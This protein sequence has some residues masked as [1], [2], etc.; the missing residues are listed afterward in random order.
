MKNAV[1]LLALVGCLPV[2]PP[3]T[4]GEDTGPGPDTAV[5]NAAPSA[6]EIAL[7]PSAPADAQDLVVT[8]LTPSED[9]EGA[10]V[11]YRYA[12]TVNGAPVALDGDTVPAAETADGQTWVVTV[13]PSDGAIDGDAATASVVIGNAPPTTPALRFEPEVPVPGEAFTLVVDSADPDGD[14][15]VTE[16]TWWVDG[17]EHQGLAD[18]TEIPG[19]Y[20]DGGE[21]YRAL[22]RVSDGLHAPVTAEATVAVGNTPPTV[23]AV[24]VE[25]ERPKDGDALAAVVEGAVDP[26]GHDLAY[27]YVW[28][29]DG[30]EAT[31]V[32]NSATVPAD[33][34]TVGEEWTLTV[35]VGDGTDEVS[36]SAPAVAIHDWEGWQYTQTFLAYVPADGAGAQTGSWSIEMLTRGGRTGDNACDLVYALDGVATDER[37]PDC[38]YGFTTTLTYDAAASVPGTGALCEEYAD[39][40]FGEWRYVDGRGL[41]SLQWP[42]AEAGY[43]GYMGFELVG[44]GEGGFTEVSEGIYYSRYHEVTRTEDEAGNVTLEAWLSVTRR[45]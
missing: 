23:T 29:R 43:G 33:A 41:Q 11:T 5:E 14:A 30:V 3:S 16:V 13:T 18:L 44:Y 32:G 35:L 20:T 39:D 24:R 2:T 22:V 8:I 9:P 4:D 31:D 38:E 12:W 7:A 26:D 42:G 6:P 27:T 37:C 34:T 17:S 25:P 15:L 36:A 40:G 45:Y 19:R 21:V 10:A 28:H 1:L